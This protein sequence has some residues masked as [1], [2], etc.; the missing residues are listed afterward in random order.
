[1]PAKRGGSSGYTRERGNGGAGGGTTGGGASSGISP[2]QRARYE[3]ADYQIDGLG[4][5][6]IDRGV[7]IDAGG[8]V[9]K[10]TLKTDHS[11]DYFTVDVTAK[12]GKRSFSERTQSATI[13]AAK[14][15]ARSKI[16]VEWT[17]DTIYGRRR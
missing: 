16:P 3:R 11:A 10:I 17:W 13:D 12:D 6:R 1:M 7:T 5:G 14:E 15:Y 8:D 9:G 2:Q 4:K